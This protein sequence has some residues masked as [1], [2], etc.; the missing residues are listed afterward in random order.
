MKIAFV[1]TYNRSKLLKSV[2]EGEDPDNALYGFNHFGE[3]KAYMCETNDSL[4]RFLNLVF[5][6]LNSLFMRQIDIDFKLARAILMIPQLNKA[7]VIVANIDGMAL[8]V[9]FLKRLK[10]V[11]PPL[12]YAV[13]LFY[14]K[15][16]IL[17][18][19]E[20]KRI[21]FF[22]KFYKWLIGGADYIL[23]H[24]PIERE[25][26]KSLGV[27]NPATCTFIPMGSDSKFFTSAKMGKIK[28]HLVLSVG[29][30]RARDY[31]TLLETAQKLPHV[32][33]ALVCR[34]A[35]I[36]NY[37]IPKNVQTF[38][39][40][41]YHKILDLY[42]KASII[43]IPINEMQRSSGQMTLTDTIQTAKPLIITKVVGIEHY[44][45]QNRQ[46]CI[47]VNPKDPNELENSIEDL[48]KNNALRNKIKNNLKK[49]AKSYNTKNYA[50]ELSKV[51]DWAIDPVKLLP[52]R[53][54]DLA[55]IRNLRNANRRHFINDGLISQKQQSSWY[56][57][58]LEKYGEY[59]FILEKNGVRTGMGAIYSINYKSKSAEI[60]R[61]AIEEKFR[62]TGLGKSLLRKIEYI[63]FKKLYLKRLKLEVF[64][65]NFRAL[66]LYKSSGFATV[67]K[68][69]VLGRTLIVMTKASSPG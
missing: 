24:A 17:R 68:R 34:K 60:G 4:E 23:Y 28:K 6:P 66:N 53:K 69:K 48:I 49:L 25:K 29:K 19:I 30:D 39:D 37:H 1:Y 35:N 50:K 67:K 11:K 9:A 33:F 61:F 46:N 55:F 64:E 52:V 31:K 21:S 44:N 38:F 22:L 20:S 18:S 47:L 2:L 65:D 3:N 8:A 42:T 63:G 51:I 27:F 40:I 26:L 54:K 43:V 10:I 62:S 7:D 45:L 56:K 12:I 14:I 36:K 5:A 15:G 32:D 58:Y 41:P 16:K 59:M 13:G 57:N